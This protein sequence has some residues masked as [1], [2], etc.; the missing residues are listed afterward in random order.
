MLG[1]VVTPRAQDWLRNS[2]SARVLHLFGG[3][4]NLANER[5]EVLSLVSPHIGPGPFTAVLSAGL[6]DNLSASDPVA[7]HPSNDALSIGH[8]SVDLARA[9]V[10]Q[11]RPDWTRLQ[12]FDV[13]QCPPSELPPAIGDTLRQALGGLAAGD[14]PACRAAVE[15]LAGRG[16]GLTPTGDDVLMGVMYG[17]WVWGARGDWPQRIAETAAPHTT[18]LSAAFL[19]AA[20]TGEAVRQW[21]DLA[22]GRPNAVESILAI[23]HTSGADTWA[24]FAR[25]WPVLKDVVLS[26]GR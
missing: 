24:G 14:W 9:A 22:N 18:T 26:T 10:W 23:G 15:R 6:P 4:C 1:K 2:R 11:P 3:V 12:T 16:E 7:L 19:R 17:L 25:A 13:T 8:L 5:D 21:H 20:A